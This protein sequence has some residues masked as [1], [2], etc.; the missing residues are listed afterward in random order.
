MSKWTFGIITAG[1][2][3]ARERV[4]K[5]IF[6]IYAQNIP[7]DNYE[8]IIVGG[9]PFNG[10][11]LRHIPFDERVRKAW[12]TRKKNIVAH[13][14]RFENLCLMHDYIILKD[15][16]YEGYEKFGYEWD[17]CI[18]PIANKDGL[19][20]RDWVTWLSPP[21]EHPNAQTVQFL[22]YHDDS[23]IREQYISGSYYCVKKKW[24]IKWPLDERR[25]WGESEDVEWSHLCRPYWVYKCN[26]DSMVQFLKQKEPH[27][28]TDQ[29]L[30]E[31]I[32]D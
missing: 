13:E 10:N 3:E 2:E 7:S 5:A 12:I 22:D 8:I 20:F 28:P 26:P 32:N 16:W 29:R 15:G 11:N 14:A 1:G 9:E 24:A 21:N 31:E 25:G 4:S 23:R 6:S 18:N 19:R 17:C 30:C 27:P